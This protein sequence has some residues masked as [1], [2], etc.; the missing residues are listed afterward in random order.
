MSFQEDLVRFGDRLARLVDS[1]VPV[2][3]AASAARPGG[4]CEILG[5]AVAATLARAPGD[6]LV[7]AH[8]SAPL[9]V[10]GVT[11]PLA[12]AAQR[13][14]GHDGPVVVAHEGRAITLVD[15]VRITAALREP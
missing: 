4:G 12:R 15:A 14:N 1:G 2:K 11:E 9:P 10:A 13:L 7:T 6:D 8:L 3:D 5:A